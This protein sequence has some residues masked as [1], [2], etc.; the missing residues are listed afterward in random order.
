MH[1]CNNCSYFSLVE[2]S[3]TLTNLS[4]DDLI[5]NLM[6]LDDK[7]GQPVDQLCFVASEFEMGSRSDSFVQTFDEC[8]QLVDKKSRNDAPS[9]CREVFHGGGIQ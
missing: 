1:W 8:L 5:S 4:N 3:N 7:I 9:N 2:S 6:V